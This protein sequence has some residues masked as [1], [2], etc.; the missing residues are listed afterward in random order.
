MGGADS[1]FRLYRPT[2]PRRLDGLAFYAL[3]PFRVARE[4]RDFRPDAVLAQGGQETALVLLG[5]RLARVPTRVIAD[6][7]GDPA[8]PARGSTALRC[9]SSC[10][11]SP[12]RSPGAG[13]GRPT[14]CGRSPL[15]PRVSSATSARSRRRPL[16]RLW[17]STRSSRRHPRRSPSVGRALRRRARAL[18][19]GRRARRGMAPRRAARAGGDTA[20]RRSRDAA[21]G[22]RAPRHGLSGASAL[23]R[24]A[25]HA[26]GREGTGRA[27][28]L[29][30]PSR[31]EGLGRIVVEAFCRGRGV[32]GSRVGGIPD[33]VTDG[34]SG[35]LVSSGDAPRSR[36][37]SYARSR[38][39]SSQTASALRGVNV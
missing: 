4:L 15:T 8:A 12:T 32:V 6:V 16:R 1:R 3:L 38:I 20:H 29:V 14:A 24:V 9:G 18:Q 17:I 2:R 5:R 34:E 13:C 19:G 21:R 10:L 30:L 33:L 25:A 11:L 28:V 7:H 39:G 26:R 31:S 37:R 27:T 35:I 36:T 23:G 22:R